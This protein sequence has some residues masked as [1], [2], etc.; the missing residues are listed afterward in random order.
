MLKKVVY[1]GIVFN[2]DYKINERGD[3]FSPYRGW[4]TLKPYKIKKGYY[5]VHLMTSNGG[6]FFMIHRLVLEAFAP[7]ENSLDKQVN[8]KDGDKSNNFLTNLEW[9]TQ[10]EN[11]EHSVRIGLRDNMPKG[12]N[13]SCNILTEDQVLQICEELQDP[14]RE[15]YFKIGNRYGV[16]KHAIYD[17]KR[18]KS[19]SWLTKEYNFK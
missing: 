18:K 10:T 1:P 9:C 13:A 12:E 4:H 19:W 15:S 3:V 17:I 6:K 16:S 7:I 11:M 5:R 14:N 8:H 2:Q